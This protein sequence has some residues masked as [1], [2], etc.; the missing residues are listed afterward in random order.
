MILSI[1][2]LIGFSVVGAFF[3]T[4]LSNESEES[5]V[6][7]S[8]MLNATSFEISVT[9]LGF[10]LI[11]IFFTKDIFSFLINRNILKFVNNSSHLLRLKL[12][13]NYQYQ[14]FQRYLESNSS[15]YIQ[16]VTEYCYLFNVCLVGVLKMFSDIILLIVVSCFFLFLFG[17]YIM[18]ALF[19]LALVIILY[20][21]ILKLYK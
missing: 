5:S 18:I 11:I 1:L 12:I 15:Q 4:L 2:D 6:F 13:K 19:V 21:K 8:K 14:T 16:S 10:I 7:L 9:T 17:F 3:G 20:D